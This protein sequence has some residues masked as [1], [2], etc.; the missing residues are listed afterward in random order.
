[1]GKE[2]Y[3]LSISYSE[4]EMC[5]LDCEKLSKHFETGSIFTSSASKKQ[6]LNQVCARFYDSVFY[7]LIQT[8]CKQANE[9]GEKIPHGISYIKAL[10]RYTCTLKPMYRKS[11][12]KFLGYRYQEYFDRK[13]K[14]VSKILLSKI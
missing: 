10:N 7:D 9:S 6:K 4:Y 5:F 8:K 12:A 1:M 3:I 14:D 2:K 13:T 11:I